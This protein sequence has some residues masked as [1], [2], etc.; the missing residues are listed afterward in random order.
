MCPL[1]GTET[2]L[3]VMDEEKTTQCSACGAFKDINPN[4]GNTVWMKNG[5]VML[6][7]EDVKNQK[8]KHLKRYS[9]V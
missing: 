8:K 3:K 1:C 5:R 9:Y 6:A 2:V 4:S 7:E